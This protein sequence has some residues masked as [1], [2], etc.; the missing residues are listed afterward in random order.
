MKLVQRWLWM[1]LGFFTAGLIVRL[2]FCREA[3]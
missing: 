1:L 2:F 3:W